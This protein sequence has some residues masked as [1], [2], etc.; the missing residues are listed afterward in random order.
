MDT[1]PQ[2]VALAHGYVHSPALPAHKRGMRHP[3]HLLAGVAVR[4]V[5][6]AANVVEPSPA[7]FQGAPLKV[8]R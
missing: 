1:S 7:K 3:I 8:A 5:V 4:N 6:S 2:V